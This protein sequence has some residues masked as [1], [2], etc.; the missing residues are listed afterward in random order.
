MDQRKQGKMHWL[1][2]Q[3][4]RNVDNIKNVRHEASRLFR[5]KKDSESY[6]IEHVTYSKNK[7]IRDLYR[8]ISDIKKSYQS[9]STTVKD[10][11]GD[12]VTDCYSI[13]ARWRNHFCQLLNVHG[14]NDVRLKHIPRTAEPLEPDPMRL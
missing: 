11:K 12:L 2:D 7:N 3:N 4:Q 10:G 13:L 5:N 6:I 8:G 1:Q 9:R 14:V